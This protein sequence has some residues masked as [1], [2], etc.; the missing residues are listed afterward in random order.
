MWGGLDLAS[1]PQLEVGIL[2]AVKT[3]PLNFDVSDLTFMDSTGLHASLDVARALQS[4]CLI[5]HGV[6][7]GVK[8]VFDIFGLQ[9][10][11]NLHIIYCSIARTPGVALS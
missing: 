1:V 4:G 10:M 9:V 2:E 11:P 3:G 7:N 6:Q 5:L 8:K